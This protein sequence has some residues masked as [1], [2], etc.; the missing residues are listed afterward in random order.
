M[1]EAR[2]VRC[3]GYVRVSTQ[4]QADLEHGSLDAQADEIRQYLKFRQTPETKF[5]VTEV[6]REEGKSGK[7]IDRPELKK[8]M[9]SIRRGQ[10]DAV[11]VTKI[12]R[13]TRSVKDFYDLWGLFQEFNV[14]LI[15]VRDQFDTTTP[16]GKAM[17]NMILTF[18]Q[19]EREMTAERVRNK[20]LWHA[21]QGYWTGGRPPGYRLDPKEKGVLFPHPDERGF[22]ELVFKKYIDL[23][24]A[25]ELAKYLAKQGIKTPVYTS[26][27]GRKMGGQPVY[28]SV[29]LNMLRNPVYIGKIKH[30]GK[31]FPGKHEPIISEQLFNQVNEHLTTHAP[32]R[33]NPRAPREHVYVLQSLVFC[34][35]CGSHM[36]PKAC[37]GSKRMNFYYQCTKNNHSVGTVCTMR[38]APAEALE[39]AIL[40]QVREIALNATE[41]E[42]IVRDANVHSNDSLRELSENRRRT[43]VALREVT[44]KARKLVDVLAQQGAAGL[45]IVG[46]E[47]RKLESQ[48]KALERQ[49]AEIKQEQS[50]VERESMDA[51]VMVTSLKTF[52]EVVDK[53]IPEEMKNLLPMFVERVVFHEPDAKGQGEIQLSLYERPVRPEGGA[54]PSVALSAQSSEWYALVR[55]FRTALQDSIRKP[56]VTNSK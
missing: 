41:V 49:L 11:V 42:R 3:T 2:T 17:V 37:S 53:A 19:L 51:V 10:V 15:S 26:R 33:K 21:E 28:V 16:M 46:D 23:G 32:K 44:E 7:D 35:Q 45:D 4:K 43:E 54:N 6:L 12:D 14:Q 1:K 31:V 25:C 18:A 8:L 34:G 22:V 36:T 38:Y 13:L 56:A 20:M 39:K 5:D 30:A 55:D 27:R 9:A 50:L 24:S 29:I 40:E 52:A 48:R 47:L